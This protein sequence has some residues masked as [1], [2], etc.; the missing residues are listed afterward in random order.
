MTTNDSSRGDR[1]M[2]SISEGQKRRWYRDSMTAIAPPVVSQLSDSDL[3]TR[4]RCAAQNERHATAELIVLLM[5]IDA[6]QLYLAQGFSSLFTYCTRALRLSEHAAYGRIEAARAAR[7]FPV[8]LELLERGDLTLTAV[9][10][11][12]PH[13]TLRTIARCWSARAP[14]D[15]A[16]D[17]GDRRRTASATTRAEHGATGPADRPRACNV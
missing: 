11:L 10:L 14:S 7:C 6:R 9:G 15:K 13:L 8:V 17:R 4:T 12:R 16:R 3:L 1:R 5:E 2:W